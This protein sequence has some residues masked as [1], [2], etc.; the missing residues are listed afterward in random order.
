MAKFWWVENTDREKDSNDSVHARASNY[1]AMLFA[2]P[3][4]SKYQWSR[5]NAEHSISWSDHLRATSEQYWT[6]RL[7]V[8]LQRESLNLTLPCTWNQLRHPQRRQA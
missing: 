7:I 5:H 1:L 3:K 6:N 4:A 8:D 2:Q